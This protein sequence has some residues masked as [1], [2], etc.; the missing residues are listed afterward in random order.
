MRKTGCGK[1]CHRPS[2]DGKYRAHAGTKLEKVKR[3][4]LRHAILER[5][6]RK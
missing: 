3:E 5:D 2:K 1:L 4:M 6:T